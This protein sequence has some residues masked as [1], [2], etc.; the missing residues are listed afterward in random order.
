MINERERGA[1]G[2]H[3]IVFLP[4]RQHSKGKKMCRCN[5]SDFLLTSIIL[6]LPFKGLDNAE[7][8]QCHSRLKMSENRVCVRVCEIERE[9]QREEYLITVHLRRKPYWGDA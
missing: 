5:A 8:Q 7:K 1:R 2:M 3:I 9:R 4:Q 6:C